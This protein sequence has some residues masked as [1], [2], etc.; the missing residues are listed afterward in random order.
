[1]GELPDYFAEP[2]DLAVE[3]ASPGQGLGALQQRCRDLVSLG[4]ALV[5]LVIPQPRS[6]RAVYVFRDG[7]EIGPLRGADVVDLTDLAAGLRLTVE[8]I[9]SALRA[10]PA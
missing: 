10:R 5:L 8:D 1:D 7:S 6:R 2:P 4:V 9:F 3:I